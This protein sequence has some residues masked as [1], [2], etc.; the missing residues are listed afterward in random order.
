MQK[1]ETFPEKTYAELIRELESLADPIRAKTHAWFFK[2]GPGQY[3]EGDVFLGIRVPIQ[4]KVAAR[5]RDLPLKDIRRLLRSK[6]HEHRFVALEILVMRYERLKKDDDKAGIKKVVDFYLSQTDRINNWDL[7][8]ASAPYILGD[9]L[10]DRPATER[11]VLTS[12][13]KSRI[14]WERRIAIVA[15]FAFI[16]AGEYDET[17]R[18]SEI[19][20]KDGHDLIHKAVG[21]MLR[22]VGKRSIGTEKRFLDTY[23]RQMPRTTLRYAIEKFPPEIRAHYLHLK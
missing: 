16:R 3:G 17:L 8:D 15:T 22:E 18:I 4:R 7:V 6:V 23:V 12:L 20:L 10:L 9:H 21:W 14:L 2:T 11:A 5:Y 1:K 19:L 13:A